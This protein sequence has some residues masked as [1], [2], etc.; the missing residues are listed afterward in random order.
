MKNKLSRGKTI[1]KISNIKVIKI[2][3]KVK[4][5]NNKNQNYNKKLIKKLVLFTV[6]CFWF[7]NGRSSSNI[8]I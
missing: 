5:Q 1:I 4:N 6:W 2:Y 3:V 7:K 8:Q